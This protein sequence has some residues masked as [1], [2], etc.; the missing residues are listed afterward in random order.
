M[1][2]QHVLCGGLRSGRKRSDALHIDVNAPAGSANKV[3][4]H[5]DHISK[6][7]ADNIPD[8][9]TDMLEV[10]AYVYCADQFTSRG[11]S[12]MS[13][14]GE[15]WRRQFYFKV[16]VRRL[17]VWT[18]PE[19]H[20]ALCDTLDFLSEDE[21]HFEFVGSPMSLPL[22]SYLPLAD[23]GAHSIVPDEVILFSGGLDS[24]AGTADAMIG[25]GKKVALVSHQGSTMIASKQKALDPART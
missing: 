9:L 20:Q 8:V 25:A 15:K 1:R 17:E 18:R 12:Q 24:L 21:F 13:A 7:L 22:Q 2:E 6:R 4:L 14:M 10:A 5:I 19:V 23:S 16:P 3:N 11:T